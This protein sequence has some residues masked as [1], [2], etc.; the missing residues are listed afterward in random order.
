MRTTL[1]F[2]DA[3]LREAKRTAA[4]RRMTL[5]RLI[6]A[7]LQRYLRGPA[8]SGKRYRLDLPVVKGRRQPPVDVS[9]RNALYDFFDA[10]R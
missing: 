2:N 6:E 4:E 8:A 5:T 3:L 7:A 10:Q 9:D 1:D